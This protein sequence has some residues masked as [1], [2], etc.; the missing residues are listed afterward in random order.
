MDAE[1]QI[2]F[3]VAHPE[4]RG[5]HQRLDL[6]GSQPVLELLA[7]ICLTRVRGHV[8]T[9]FAQEAGQPLGLG[10]GQNVDDPRSRHRLQRIGDPGIA[11]QR[12]QSRHD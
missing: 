9:A 11:L 6:V 3:V 4:R 10:D 8:E 7:I 2:R 1:R 5:R 12:A